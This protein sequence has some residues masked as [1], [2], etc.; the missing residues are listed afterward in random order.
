VCFNK[1]Q[2]NLKVN[3]EVSDILTARLALIAI[4]PEALQSEQLADGRL[5]SITSAAV[6]AE[7]PPEHWEP[8]VFE[9]LLTR[10]AADSTEVGWHRYIALRHDGSRTL[11]GTMGGFRKAETPEECE[12]GYSVV[13]EF[14][15]NGYATEAT[16]AMMEWALAHPYLRAIS[17]QTFPSLPKSIRVMEKCGMEFAGAGDEEGTV[18]YRLRRTACSAQ[19]TP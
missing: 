5:G 13:P 14:Q 11:I 18:R 10:F 19:A 16:Q 15:G 6:P 2:E 9:L 7:W 17:A 12:V 1:V 8:H 3:L 4:T